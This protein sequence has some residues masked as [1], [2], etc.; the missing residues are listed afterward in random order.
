MF[1]NLS[2]GKLE[3]QHNLSDYIGN[4]V[5]G[6]IFSTGIKFLSRI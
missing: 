4:N 6:I 2:T 3:Y 1:K 5:I